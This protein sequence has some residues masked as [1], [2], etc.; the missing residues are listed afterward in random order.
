[1][2]SSY[3]RAVRAPE[4]ESLELEELNPVERMNY[5]PVWNRILPMLEVTGSASRRTIS[6]PEGRYRL[7][8]DPAEPGSVLST[9]HR[10]KGLEANRVFI[11]QPDLLRRP[12]G[13]AAWQMEQEH[14]LHYVAL[15]RSKNTLIFV[16]EP[17][18]PK[19]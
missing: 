19:K 7:T 12:R 17:S 10:A 2:R 13:R 9:I 18:K 1:M 11:L 8:F 3:Q 5:R 14:N 16:E 6:N 4:V 15:T